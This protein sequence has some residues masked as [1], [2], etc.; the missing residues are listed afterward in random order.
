MSNCSA[1]QLANCPK[2]LHLGWVGLTL[3]CK[4]TELTDFLL[5]WTTLDILSDDHMG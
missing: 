4:F 1:N 3:N 2:M 5:G